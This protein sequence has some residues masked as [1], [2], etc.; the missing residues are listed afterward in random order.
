MPSALY[1]LGRRETVAHVKAGGLVGGSD[2]RADGGNVN[3]KGSTSK[4]EFWVNA[5]KDVDEAVEYQRSSD[6]MYQ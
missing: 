1:A 3:L 4:L 6:R 5:S 2:Q